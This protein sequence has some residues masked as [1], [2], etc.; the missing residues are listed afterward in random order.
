MSRAIV[1]NVEDAALLRIFGASKKVS[2]II[3]SIEPITLSPDLSLPEIRHI[4]SSFRFSYSPDPPLTAVPESPLYSPS[5]DS[6]P[7]IRSI[8]FA[9]SSALPSPAVPSFAF[10]FPEAHLIEISELNA[11]E[12]SARML[13]ESER[14]SLPYERRMRSLNARKER[15]IEAKKADGDFCLF[16]NFFENREQAEEKVEK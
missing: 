3:S 10:Q 1:L 14:L 5:S 9:S 7:S 13:E 6:V 16:E 11:P 15:M 8:P 12:P 2:K 4:P